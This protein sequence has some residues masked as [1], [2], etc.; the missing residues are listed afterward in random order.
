MKR[1]GILT[2]HWVSNFGANLQTL[3]TYKHIENAGDYPI[4][5]NWIPD[6]LRRIYDK[7][8]SIEQNNAH[9]E[10][11]NKYYKNITRICKDKYDIAKVIDEENID[12][13]VI[14]SDAVFSY[15]PFWTRIRL[16]RRGLWYFKPISDFDCPN[17]FWGDF[18]SLV[19]RPIKIVAMS[20]SAQNTPYKKI[21][22]KKEK[23][24]FVEAL[25][26][27]SYVSVRDIWTKKMLNHLSGMERNTPI[28]PDPVFAFNQNVKP[29]KSDYAEKILGV[30]GKYAILSLSDT[31]VEPEWIKTLEQLFAEQGITLVGLP[32]TNKSFTDVLAYNVKFPLDPMDWYCFIKESE[33]YIGELMHPILVSLHNAVPIFAFDTYGFKKGDALDEE[34]S[35]TFQIVMRFGLL[36]NYYHK[37]RQQSLP[38]PQYVFDKI[39]AFDKAHCN[40]K[41]G[42]RYQEYIEMMNHIRNL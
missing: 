5:I 8:V 35:K 9:L 30:K 27:F 40:L 6:D 33:A 14:G 26:N 13:V 41:A 4:I 11:I 16:C 18:Y 23:R 12:V 19:K 28:T 25:R 21:N 39:M 42:E 1:I 7:K 3:S 24:K 20:A 2:Y 36:D 38:T 37:L 17:P 32:Q 15:T 29:E 34:S 31:K 22:T 10:F